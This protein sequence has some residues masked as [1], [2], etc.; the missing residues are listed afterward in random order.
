MCLW[1]EAIPI[2]LFAFHYIRPY[3]FLILQEFSQKARSFAND[4]CQHADINLT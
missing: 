3:D 2:L 4:S 1:P